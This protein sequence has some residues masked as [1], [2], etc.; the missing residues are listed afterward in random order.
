MPFE[1]K[2]RIASNSGL[3]QNFATWKLDILG[4]RF[5]FVIRSALT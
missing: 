3:L 1:C 4:A 2:A 5:E